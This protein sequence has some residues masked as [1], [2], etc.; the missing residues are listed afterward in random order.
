MCMYT[1][2][3]VFGMCLFR[4]CRFLG[5]HKTCA[6][7][8]HLIKATGT[9]YQFPDI[10]SQLRCMYQWVYMPQLCSCVCVYVCACLCVCVCVFC[11][12]VR[13]CAGR[14]CIRVRVFEFGVCFVCVCVF[15]CGVWC[16]CFLRMCA[17]FF[18]G[19]LVCA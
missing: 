13:V 7:F 10:L 19:V 3:C 17:W 15:V 11:L 14:F 6:F 5:C 2:V 16:V 18:S 12:C 1:F 8:C 9:E 4:V